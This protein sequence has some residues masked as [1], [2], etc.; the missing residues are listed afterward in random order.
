MSGR[1][2]KWLGGGRG[3]RPAWGGGS[4]EGGRNVQEIDREGQASTT[5]MP[6]LEPVL[7]S[8]A[9]ERCRGHPPRAPGPSLALWEGSFHSWELRGLAKGV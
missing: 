2:E 5:Q 4:V 9:Q 8:L 6:P 1:Y 3:E 7:S